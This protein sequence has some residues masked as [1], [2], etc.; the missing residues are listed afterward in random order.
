MPRR[1]LAVWLGDSFY[2]KRL[3]TS[4]IRV[5]GTPLPEGDELLPVEFSFPG[6]YRDEERPG[7]LR[8]EGQWGIEAVSGQEIRW[9]VRF[10]REPIGEEE[11]R[12]HKCVCWG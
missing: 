3:R 5:N 10:Y 11:L 9:R 4:R 2:T 8:V 12:G 7:D 1:S 6:E